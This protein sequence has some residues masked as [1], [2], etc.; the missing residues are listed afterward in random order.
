MLLIDAY[1]VL[2]TPG[3]LPLGLA[4]VDLAG[5]VSLIEGSRYRQRPVVLVCDGASKSLPS[6]NLK[7]GSASVVY[8]GP[9]ADADG[10]IERML[11]DDSAPR[12]FLVVSSDR[13][14]V[15]ASRAARAASIS[16][17][18][19]L[20]EL[21][22]DDAKGRPEPLPAWVRQIPLGHAAMVDWFQEFGLG[23]P[24]ARRSSETPA[25]PR[26]EPPVVRRSRTDIATPLRG[27]ASPPAAQDPRPSP[28][29]FEITDP[30]L[31]RALQE[32]GGK[33]NVDDLDMSRW[34]GPP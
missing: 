25:Q 22:A 17:A 21:S 1:N 6:N 14:V 13:R 16:S 23:E 5:L 19:F 30:V 15:R 34:I 9:G 18:R 3:V 32:W 27:P 8:A 33:L 12:R 11:R 31:L 2:H 24:E 29:R 4:G 7:I 20:H 26:P 28:G 10:V